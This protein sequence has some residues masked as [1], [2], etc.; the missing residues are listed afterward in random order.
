MQAEI[1]LD[2]MYMKSP[3]RETDMGRRIDLLLPQPLR[4]F[5]IIA[6]LL[7]GGC[8]IHP[9]PENVT[10]LNTYQIV[11]K[12]RCE[13]R[14]AIKDRAIQL[15]LDDNVVSE[16][17]R[18]GAVNFI[19][20]HIEKW[21][22]LPL[23]K[24]SK[25][26]QRLIDKYHD[27]L[28]HFDFTLRIS[29]ENNLSTEVNL[30]STLV[31]GSNGLGIKA[32]NN[33]TRKN[34]RNFRVKDSFAAI[35][36]TNLTCKGASRESDYLYPITGE[37]GLKEVVWTFLDLNELQHLSKGE[38]ANLFT[39]TLVFTTT[40][41]GSASPKVTLSPIGKAL[42]IANAGFTNELKRMDEHEVLIGLALPDNKEKT[43]KNRS[44]L[45]VNETTPNLLPSSRLGLS[46]DKTL[47]SYQLDQLMNFQL[48]RNA[49]LSL[50]DQR[51]VNLS[52]FP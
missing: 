10:G 17:D 20:E 31:S 27:A 45:V 30:L 41:D 49:L 3:D 40:F 21:R 52:L 18:R 36:S 46:T 34:T 16:R 13:A 44:F 23:E 29:E 5:A 19:E 24:F 14:R 26:T 38:G 9:L 25:E 7:A 28:I 2:I 8:A 12:I 4:S 11:N 32:S 35:L 48:E 37:I 51:S 22:D 33:R 47:Y 50:R 39:D 1:S 42:S 6:T 15:I 43:G